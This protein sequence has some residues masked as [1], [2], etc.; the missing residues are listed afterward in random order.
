MEVQKIQKS[1]E[2]KAARITSDMKLYRVQRKLDA[3][4][5]TSG[6]CM[7][8]KQSQLQQS[9]P[10]EGSRSSPTPQQLEIE[11]MRAFLVVL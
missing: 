3:A 6:R 1:F 10:R 8:D 11:K 2:A 7:Q 9:R 4:Q 5:R